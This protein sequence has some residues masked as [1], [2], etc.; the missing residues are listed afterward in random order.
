MAVSLTF[1]SDGRP[2][3][4][5]IES[6]LGKYECYEI[7][8][9]KVGDLAKKFGRRLTF[10]AIAMGAHDD[11][12]M[13][14]R[15]VDA[16]DDYG[17]HAD[18]CLPSMTSSALGEVFTSVATSISS[19]QLELTDAIT[20]KQRQVRNV[21]RESKRKAGQEILRVSGHDFWIYAQYQITR[22]IYKEWVEMG[23][24]NKRVYRHEYEK[25][26]LQHPQARYVAFAK[27]SFGEGAERFAHR[28]FE[29]AADCRTIVGKAMVA[30]E[31]RLILDDSDEKAR[32][33]FTATFCKTQQLAR[34]LAKEF[35][36]KLNESNLDSRTPTVSFLDC[37]IYEL[38]DYNLGV[39]SVLVE[40]KLD[41][42]KW[43]KWNANNGFVKG[44]KKAPVFSEASLEASLR[45]AEMNMT[46]IA[47]FEGDVIE[48]GSEEEEEESEARE[49]LQ[50]KR[51]LVFTPLE[52]AQAFSHF[53]YLA[54]G[55]KRLV[56]DLQGVHDEA[57]NVLI[58]SDPVIHYHNPRGYTSRTN[59]HGRTDHGKK[60]M[61]KFFHTHAQYCGPLCRMVNGG[62]Q[63]VEKFETDDPAEGD[64]KIS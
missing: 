17:A 37:S 28:F 31:S 11:F 24:D 49:L 44:M 57:K 55:K 13:L 30:K 10:K 64:C 6:G 12:D 58:F 41:Q 4:A 18:F 56:C 46:R 59:V 48:E 33:Q 45:Q 53:S 25:T 39:L 61:H 23:S 9:N 19:T 60:G 2:S 43:Q 8:E 51:A 22:K 63:K 16:A 54:S 29:L 52:V 21:L 42:K 3:D 62:F 36:D 32:R 14:K 50:G 7:I 40:D 15:M 26:V 1:L 34:R 35:N 47:H 20:K 27:N 5:A 38:Y